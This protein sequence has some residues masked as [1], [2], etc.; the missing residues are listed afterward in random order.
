M[1]PALYA[2]EV[3]VDVTR[4]FSFFHDLVTKSNNWSSNSLRFSLASFTISLGDSLTRLETCLPRAV[5]IV[6]LFFDVIGLL[7]RTS[8]KNSVKTSGMHG[9]WD[10]A[11]GMVCT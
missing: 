6:F 10:V 2:G 11:Q 1:K 9:I 4:C 7:P 8:I 3:I 5:M